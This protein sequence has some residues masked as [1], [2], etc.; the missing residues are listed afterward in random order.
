[1]WLAFYNPSVGDVLMLTSGPIA[2]KD[3]EV[4][5]ID[6]TMTLIKHKATGEVVSINLFG[7]SQ[8]LGLTS[9]GEVILSLN[10]VKQVN[11]LL[12]DKGVS[13]TLTEEYDPKFVVGYVES[14]HA[15][16]DSDHLS[17]TQTRVN[18][19]ESL[20]IVCGAQNIRQ[21]LKVLVAKVGAVMPSGAIIWE[22]DLRGVPSH[23][24]ICSTRELGL[25]DLEDFPGIWELAEEFQPGTPLSQVVQAYRG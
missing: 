7:V 13:V 16:E 8:A 22:G 24:M 12:A 23:G 10:Q 25:S 3:V 18:N 6:N 17:V 11:Q 14:C 1:M 4:E 9:R 20:Q 5:S 19:D 21:G 2:Q 15:H